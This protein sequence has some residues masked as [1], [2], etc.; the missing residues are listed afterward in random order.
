MVGGVALDPVLDTIVAEIVS[1]GQALAHLNRHGGVFGPQL[2]QSAH[3]FK[4]A[5]NEA[6]KV[7]WPRLKFIGGGACIRHSRASWSGSVTAWQLPLMLG[8][9][10]R[11]IYFPAETVAM[12]NQ[13][14]RT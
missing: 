8:M 1:S 3:A 9:G 7:P 11:C 5:V 10:R 13:L 12:L 2:I 6:A 4:G 14:D